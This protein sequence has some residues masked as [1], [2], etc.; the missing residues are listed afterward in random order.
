M[1]WP[2]HRLPP[3]HARWRTRRARLSLRRP[4]WPPAL[5]EVR[6]VG[7][8]LD[9]D[10]RAR[11]IAGSARSPRRLD[12]HALSGRGARALRMLGSVPRP[13]LADRPLHAPAL[14]ARR[15]GGLS[16]TGAAPVAR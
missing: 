14:H 10:R 11:R 16:R 3:P 9:A 15:L 12:V 13:A 4:A 8:A 7:G 1:G 5:R 2:A 6:V